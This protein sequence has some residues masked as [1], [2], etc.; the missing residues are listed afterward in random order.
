MSI[1][2]N[3]PAT[4]P[5]R[6]VNII[7][8]AIT[9]VIVSV[10]AIVLAVIVTSILPSRWH[11]QLNVKNTGTKPVTFSFKGG[12]FVTQPG[13]TWS[14]SFYGG[15]TLTIHAGGDANA[16]SITVPLPAGN[17]KSWSFNPIAQHWTAEV[18]AD[19]PQNIRFENRRYVEITAPPSEP[20]PWP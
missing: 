16:P 17:P 19:D 4:V 11:P 20:Q 2:E 9:G 8:N 12:T 3:A 15:D 13:Q 1:P 7:N 10:S 18:N 5:S 14:N 6:R